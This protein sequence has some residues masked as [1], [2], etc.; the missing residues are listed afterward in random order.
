MKPIRKNIKLP[1]GME[2]HF[3]LQGI[4]GWELRT[5]LDFGVHCIQLV[6]GNGR[7]EKSVQV[8]FFTYDYEEEKGY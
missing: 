8:R 1:F 3:N 5:G 4:W 6:V 7:K 2:Y